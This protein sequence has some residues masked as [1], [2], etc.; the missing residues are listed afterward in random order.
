MVPHVIESIPPLV[1]GGSNGAAKATE[2]VQVDVLHAD[3]N[4][5]S[6][7]SSQDGWT[8]KTDDDHAV[9]AIRNLTL[10]ITMQ[11]G[12]GHG[13]SAVG[14]AAIGVALWKYTMRYNPNNPDWFDRDRFV[15][16]NGHASMF[17][18]TMNHLVGY[19]AWTMDEL[20]GYG[21]A[22]LNGFKTLAHA[23][24]EIDCPGIEVTTGPLGQGI[25]NAVGM[26]M[27]SK[28]LAA[29]F[30]EPGY[31]VVQSK[32]YCMTGDGCLMEGVAL[33]G[34]YTSS[35]FPVQTLRMYSSAPQPLPWRVI[36]ASITWY[37]STTTIKSLVMGRYHGSTARTSTRRCLHADGRY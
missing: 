16:S 1:N 32:I 31:D 14:M 22:K 35:H 4:D 10:D 36:S 3:H 27:A 37:F 29:R 15:L 2:G 11:N 23:H 24:P 7:Q 8:P 5:Q 6:N 19:E 13:G 18:Y 30:N 34:L 12:G 17:L 9:L 28:N 25:A 26:A 20:K 21:N 33:E